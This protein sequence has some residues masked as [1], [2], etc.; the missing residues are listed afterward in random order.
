[1]LLTE[2]LGSRAIGSLIWSKSGRRPMS[3]FCVYVDG[4]IFYHQHLS[5]LATTEVKVKENKESID[6]LTLSDMRL[7]FAELGAAIERLWRQ[8]IINC[9]KKR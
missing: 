7:K 5:K 8:I 9:M 6:S 1:M 4:A 2:E 3:L